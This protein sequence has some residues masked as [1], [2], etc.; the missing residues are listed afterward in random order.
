MDAWNDIIW[1][2]ENEITK[3]K[4][5][6]GGINDWNDNTGTATFPKILFAIA[7]DVM[8]SSN[9]YY[10]GQRSIVS[11]AVGACV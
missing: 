5:H 3:Q 8:P 7:N 10:G 6:P 4:T 2:Q 1:F 9:G 11:S